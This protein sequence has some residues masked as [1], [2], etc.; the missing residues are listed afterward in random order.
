MNSFDE[1]LIDPPR[2]AFEATLY[3][4]V[5][6]VHRQLRQTPGTHDLRLDTCERSELQSLWHAMDQSPS[7]CREWPTR[8]RLWHPT[9]HGSFL[10]AW[11]RDYLSRWHVR[12]VGDWP[13][14]GVRLPMAGPS[15]PALARIY[16]ANSVVVT[17]HRRSRLLVV[18][19]CGTW[20]EPEAL[21]WMG[22]CCGPCF[23]RAADEPA[24]PL[25][26]NV[27]KQAITDVAVSPTGE[28]VA[29]RCSGRVEVREVSSGRLLAEWS[30]HT[31]GIAWSPNGN[32]VAVQV[33][34][35]LTATR[36]QMPGWI[37]V[38][39]SPFVFH[40]QTRSLIFLEG[41]SSRLRLQ[42]LE[43]SHIFRDFTLAPG[44]RLSDLAVSPNGQLL[45]A[46]LE[47]EVLFWDVFTGAGKARTP[48][49]GCQ[50]PLAF[51]P[52]G[53][54]LACGVSGPAR[55]L[56]L[57]DLINRRTWASLDTESVMHDFAF[58]P[59]GTLVVTT[60]DDGVRVWDVGTEVECRCLS[61]GDGRESFHSLAFTPDGRLLVLGT[62]D[63]NVRVWPAEILRGE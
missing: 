10:V 14:E 40:S 44:A 34:H 24:P 28:C 25:G 48:L 39:G 30:G 26:W 7:G 58:S 32:H 22:P 23:D 42:S 38:P 57:Y 5:D 55:G 37:G 62:S 11:W 35:R 36:D 29:S 16:P 53:N 4:A 9:N 20:G 43:S 2:G 12:L 61:S 41:Y 8:D 21:G 19:G 52:D 18:C 3:A 17:E 46:A 13:A 27:G 33:G 47:D 51:S 60:D 49:R 45:A 59:D 56:V 63:G 6:A 31:D 50:G 15:R 1:V 54:F